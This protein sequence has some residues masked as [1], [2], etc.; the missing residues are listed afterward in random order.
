VNSHLAKLEAVDAGC[1]EAIMLDSSGHV[2]EG[3]GENLFMRRG[4]EWITPPVSSDILEGVTRRLLM[5]LIRDELALDVAER[6]IDR[7]ELYVCD[8]L[9]LCGTGAEI[10]P[11]FEVDG[12][13]VGSGKAGD[14]TVRLQEAFFA[15]TRGELP[16]YAD[17]LV[18]VY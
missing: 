11:V 3:P 18:P 8:E 6:V 7:S 5:T 10:T 12:R 15:L 14:G 1:D 13:P 2:S 17:W 9:L 4:D 16:R